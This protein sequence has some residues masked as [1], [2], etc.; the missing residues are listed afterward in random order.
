MDTYT[1]P[2][3]DRAA[4]VTIECGPVAPTDQAC[5]GPRMNSDPWCTSVTRALI[6]VALS[7]A[8]Q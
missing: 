6:A 4:L 7:G 3:Y 8:D 2:D 1:S 5:S